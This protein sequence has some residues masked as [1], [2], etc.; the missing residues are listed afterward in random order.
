MPAR[1]LKTTL[2]R[3]TGAVA[4]AVFMPDGQIASVS[5]DGSI[6]VWD[7]ATEQI[8]LQQGHAGQVFAVALTPDGKQLLSAGEDRDVRIWD[9]TADPEPLVLTCDKGLIRGL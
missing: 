2:R 7:P 8:S 6:K 9:L 5:W 1:K 3:H 4:G